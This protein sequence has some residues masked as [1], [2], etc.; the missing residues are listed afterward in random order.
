MWLKP[1]TARVQHIAGMAAH[2]KGRIANSQVSHGWFKRFL[3]RQPQLS[4]CRGD[5]TANVRM[6]CLNRDA[7]TQYFDLLIE[8]LLKDVLTENNQMSSPGRIC[9]VDVIGDHGSIDQTSVMDS[10][11]NR[12]SLMDCSSDHVT[13]TSSSSDYASVTSSSSDRTSSMDSSSDHTSV[14]SSS[15]DHT[16]LMDSS[17]D[18]T[19][20]MDSSSDHT[21]LMGTV[22]SDVSIAT[23]VAVVSGSNDASSVVEHHSEVLSALQQRESRLNVKGGEGNASTAHA[24]KVSKPNAV[25]NGESRYISKYSVQFVPDA[26]SQKKEELV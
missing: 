7:M 13:V 3:Q 24:S 1:D 25:E 2:D 9:N 26:K 18:R 12:T 16:S 4:Y 21:S 14:T 6:D 15:S 23:P 10:T 5:P 8:D 11:S 20:L 19:S 17:S 22:L